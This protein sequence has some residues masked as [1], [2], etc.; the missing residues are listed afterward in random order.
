MTVECPADIV[1]PAL[2]LRFTDVV[3][4]SSPA[5]PGGGLEFVFTL[6]KER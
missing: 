4:E 5:E 1:V 2:A 3:E 6:A